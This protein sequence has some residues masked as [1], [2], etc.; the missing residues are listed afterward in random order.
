VGASSHRFPGAVSR[1]RFGWRAELDRGAL[2]LR[3]GDSKAARACFARAHALAPDEPEPALALGRE[4]W[5]LG[6]LVDAE[7]LLEQAWEARP[8]WPLAACALG[9]VLIE[10]GEIA[11][12]ERTLA[13]ALA[14]LPDHPALHMVFGELHLE[15]GRLA[16]AHESFVAAG[17]AG[18]ERWQVDR[19]LARVENGRGIALAAEA[20]GGGEK[21]TE[22]AFAFKRAADLDPAWAPPHVNLGALFHRLGRPSAARAAYLRAIAL[23]PSGGSAHFNLGLLCR[24]EDD[25]A[26]A[27]RAFVAALAADPP[28]PRARRELALVC[29]E[30]GDRA[31]AVALFEEELRATRRPDAWVY[32][33]LG[34][35]FIEA[36]EPSRAEAALRQ[37]LV[38][39]PEH[40]QAL[41]QL[42]R[43]LAGD[44]RYL[45]AAA[46][47]RRATE[48][49]ARRSGNPAPPAASK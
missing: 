28:H 49:R 35:I 10:R 27:E 29:A 40:P 33:Q 3:R 7:R 20:P 46:L 21:L 37:A 38:H 45:E 32:T 9:R 14:A 13:P 11:R 22:A 19:G 12:A 25:L 42:A 5:K 23:D 48:E 36:G 1:P 44:G 31:R 47:H 41:A 43:L 2:H 24:D 30:R 16:A 34:V 15:A 4:E 18:A 17:A 8:S 39:D 6:R 26:A